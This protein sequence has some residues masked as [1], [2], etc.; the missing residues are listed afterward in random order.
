RDAAQQGLVA[1]LTA[2][3]QPA[4][5]DKIPGF[6]CTIG[7][8]TLTYRGWGA[9][10]DE[11]TLTEKGSGFAVVYRVGGRVVGTLDVRASLCA[12]TS[13]R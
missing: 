2:A 4:T 12:E 13:N 3:G 8:F 7:R 11:C 9:G 1:G 10:Y 6:T 5:W